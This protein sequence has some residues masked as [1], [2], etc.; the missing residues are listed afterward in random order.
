MLYTN[1]RFTF[2]CAASGES[3]RIAAGTHQYPFQFS[4]PSGV[5]SSFE[6][7]VGYVR[8]TAEAKMERPWKFDHVTRSAFTVISL[9]DLNLEPPQFTV[10]L[11]R[12]VSFQTSLFHHSVSLKWP[13]RLT[14]GQVADGK[15][16]QS[17][18]AVIANV[19]SPQ[20]ELFV[21][22]TTSHKWVWC[23]EGWRGW[24]SPA[25][26]LALLC[27]CYCQSVVKIQFSTR[28]KGLDVVSMAYK[29]ISDL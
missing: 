9:V 2:L 4:L 12:H 21:R 28:L 6:G 13:P 3:Y 19:L 8:Y 20:Q 15:L 11:L 23:G 27:S 25:T 7:E 22:P 16:F 18:A 10:R 29:Y 24:A 17:R 14:I 5:P 1:P 26:W